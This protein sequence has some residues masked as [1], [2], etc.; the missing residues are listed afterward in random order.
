MPG[1][2]TLLERSMEVFSMCCLLGSMVA[3]LLVPCT[4]RERSRDMVHHTC[5]DSLTAGLKQVTAFC[6]IAHLY[7]DCIRRFWAGSVAL[8]RR[9]SW[10]TWAPHGRAMVPVTGRSTSHYRRTLHT[11]RKVVWEHFVMVWDGKG[12]HF[13]HLLRNALRLTLQSKCHLCPGCHFEL[14]QV[15]FTAAYPF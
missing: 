12:S 11:K 2:Y 13:M 4:S 14:K 10:L 1:L 7:H 3:C 15:G 9:L 6:M 5:L 8:P